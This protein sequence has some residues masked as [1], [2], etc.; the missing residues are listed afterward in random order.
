MPPKRQ[1]TSSD[2]R[3]MT[4]P[5]GRLATELPG[6]GIDPTN[7]HVW[8]VPDP[9]GVAGH[10]VEIDIPSPEAPGTTT[11]S[12]YKGISRVDFTYNDSCEVV[13]LTGY[14]TANDGE[15]LDK[16]SAR[17]AWRAYTH[18]GWAKRS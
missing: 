11:V 16:E 4:L 9:S 3:T 14:N 15:V 6:R 7:S 8:L 5:D 2:R 10:Y 12:L 18:E 1:L 13:L 17:R